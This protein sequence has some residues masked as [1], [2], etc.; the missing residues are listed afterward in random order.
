MKKLI[1]FLTVLAAVVLLGGC[2]SDMFSEEIP[3]FPQFNASA[4]SI[5]FGR[6][7]IRSTLQRTLTFSNRGGEGSVLHLYYYLE[8]DT[9]FQLLTAEQEVAL[10]P[11]DR[12]VALTI[13]FSPIRGGGATGNLVVYTSDRPLKEDVRVSTYRIG[14]RGA[15]GQSCQ[16]PGLPAAEPPAMKENRPE[17]RL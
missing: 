9:C 13:A 6:I 10:R 15:A 14:L 1:L 17:Q 12:E 11:Y 5:D 16:F 7:E 2:E 8:G 4:T 3:A